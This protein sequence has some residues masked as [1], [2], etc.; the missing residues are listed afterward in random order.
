MVERDI[1]V[2]KAKLAEQAERYEEMAEFMA[3]VANESTDLTVEERNLLSVAYK[4]VIGAKRAQWRI[5]SSLEVK[6]E[7]TGT[8]KGSIIKNYKGKIESE[9]NVTCTE[10]LN[11]LEE[12]LI[13]GAEQ[14]QSADSLVFFYKMK[15]DYYRYQAE[16]PVAVVHLIRK[17]HSKRLCQPT[18]RLKKKLIIFH[19]QVQSAWVCT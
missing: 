7:N 19:P 4:N 12:R 13:P 5:V 16:L 2:F 17:R 10:I 9:L 11:L 14:A 8:N 15:G 6:E 1:N 18:K 3:R